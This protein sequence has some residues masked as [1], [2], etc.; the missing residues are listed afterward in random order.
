[1]GISDFA[2]WPTS[3]LY[4]SRNKSKYLT[5]LRQASNN[6]PFMGVFHQLDLANRTWEAQI[7]ASLK[8]RENYD[9]KRSK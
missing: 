7:K 1:M 2:R 8:Q 3:R 5:S 4:R 6:A 9:S